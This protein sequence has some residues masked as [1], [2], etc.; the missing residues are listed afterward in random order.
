MSIRTLSSRIVYE[1]PWM[2]LREDQIELAD[3]SRGV[4]AVDRKSVV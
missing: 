2:T 1:N 3:G 4:Y